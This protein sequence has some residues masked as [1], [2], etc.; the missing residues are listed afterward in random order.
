[1]RL[2][3]PTFLL[4]VLVGC[5]PGPEETSPARQDIIQ[6]VYAS[7]KVVP[8]NSYTVFGRLP[9]YVSAIHVKAGD[10]VKTG[11]LLLEI[12]NEQNEWSISSLEEQVR[13]ARENADPSGAY[14]SALA[15]EVNAQS[16]RW[17]LDS[18]SLARTQNLYDN[19]ASS[20]QRLDQAVSQAEISRSAW[21][22]AN[23]NYNQ[24]K[25]RT[26]VEYQNLTHQLSSLESNRDDYRLLA[27]VGGRIYDVF[28]KIGSLV[29]NQ[30]PLI[31]IGDANRFEAELS[32]DET[33][34]GLLKTG[35]PVFISIDAY[36]DTVFTGTLSEV[37]PFV[38]PS[39]KSARVKTTLEALEGFPFYS[40]MSV[41]ANVIIQTKKNCL[42][43]PREFVRNGNEVMVKGEK[44]PRKIRKGIEDLQ[45]IEVLSGVTEEEVVVK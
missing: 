38:R 42:V 18:M 45:F 13:L 36:P 1:M 22:K 30:T 33:D 6:A 5:K 3:I 2:N 32:I 10:T 9:G 26:S 15:E 20:R 19:N 44:A 39:I 17:K 21:M 16:S 27:A 31:E 11:D 7:G 24:A 34:I 14:L 41:E 37:P 43:I 4:L 23:E 40:G 35:Q 25:L 8:V 12:R 28:P 29:G